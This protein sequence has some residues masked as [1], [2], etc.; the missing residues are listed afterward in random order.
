MRNKSL[1]PPLSYRIAM[2]II[3]NVH[4]PLFR[5][6]MIPALCNDVNEVYFDFS[7]ISYRKFV[8]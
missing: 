1:L 5:A 4:A 2:L 8:K 6:P 7:L 3:N